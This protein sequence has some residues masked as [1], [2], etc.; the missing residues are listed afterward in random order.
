M[1]QIHRKSPTEKFV[2]F[3]ILP[4]SLSLIINNIQFHYRLPHGKCGS[5]T[6]HEKRQNSDKHNP[7]ITHLKK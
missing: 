2:P 7:F 3:K 1:A 6:I 5:Y 4:S